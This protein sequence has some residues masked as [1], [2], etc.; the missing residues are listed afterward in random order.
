VFCCAGGLA[1][2]LAV[3]RPHGGTATVSLTSVIPLAVGLAA[4]LVACLIAARTAPRAVRPLMLALACGIC[5]GV[6]AFL[7]KLLS[8]GL[9]FQ[10]PLWAVIVVGPL[11]FLL[12]ESALQAGILIA[13][14]LSVITAADPLVSIAIAHQWLHESIAAGPV[15]ITMEV[16]ALAL[17][18]TGIVVL[19]HRAPQVAQQLDPA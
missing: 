15:N 3:A 2:F 10:W 11:G 7:F 13:P 19:A 12:N 16:A 4:V 14:V 9:V 6:M 1:W 18:I 5:Y 8:A 17:M